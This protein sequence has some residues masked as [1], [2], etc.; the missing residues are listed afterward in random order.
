MRKQ[1]LQSIAALALCCALAVPMLCACN[2]EVVLENQKILNFT[3]PEV[4][5]EIVVMTIKDYGDVKIKLFP[6]E[7]PQGVENF[8][9]LVESGYYDELIFHRVIDNFVVQGG[10]PKGDGTGGVDANGTEGFAQTISPNLQHYAGALAYAIGPDKLNASQFYIVTGLKTDDNY[11]ERLKTTYGLTYSGPVMDM[12]EQMGGRP[13]LD[14]GYEIFGQV[15]DGLEHCLA[16]QK[17]AVDAN[18]KPK[19]QVVIEKAVVVEY[20]GSGVDYLN[21]AGEQQTPAVV[22]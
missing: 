2:K 18:N 9:S 19:S 6:E 11:F 22:E 13:D 14:G 7:C 21:S 4:G 8:K 3:P 10:D 16:V 15:F 17:V 20:D 1:R 12:Y 5:E